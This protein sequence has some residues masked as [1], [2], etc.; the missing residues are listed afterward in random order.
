MSTILVY[1]EDFCHYC[2]KAKSLLDIKGLRYEEIKVKTDEDRES[3]VNLSHRK[4]L[5]QI[6]INNYHVG[7]CDDLYALNDSGELDKLID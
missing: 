4:T 5:P 7:G 3:L 1:T 6:F 2:L